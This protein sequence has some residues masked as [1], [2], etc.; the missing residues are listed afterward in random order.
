MLLFVKRSVLWKGYLN[1]NL[2]VS[3]LVYF[4]EHDLESFAVAVDHR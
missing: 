2:Q 3:V 1:V 4:H